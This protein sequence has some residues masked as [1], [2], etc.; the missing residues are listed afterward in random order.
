MVAHSLFQTLY[1][2]ND[3]LICHDDKSTFVKN[4]TTKFLYHKKIE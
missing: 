4:A 3:T 2:A 1:T